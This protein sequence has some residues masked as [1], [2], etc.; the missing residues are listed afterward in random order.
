ML[1]TGQ[2]SMSDWTARYPQ[3]ISGGANQW[4][5]RRHPFCSQIGRKRGPRPVTTVNKAP[6]FKIA[7]LA[8]TPLRQIPCQSLCKFH[9]SLTADI[10]A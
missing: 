4:R 10:P 5:H 2:N 3:L 8:H 9:S 1:L 7:A 6:L